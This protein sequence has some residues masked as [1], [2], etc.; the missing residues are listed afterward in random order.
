L[1][2]IKFA[3]VVNLEMDCGM[4]RFQN[5]FARHGAPLKRET[6]GGERKF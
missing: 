3:R 5:I 4:E 6:R 1:L 2:R